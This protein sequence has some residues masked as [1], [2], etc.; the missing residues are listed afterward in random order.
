VSGMGIFERLRS[1]VAGPRLADELATLAGQSADLVNR[2][3]RHA[4]RLAYPKIAA[5]VRE[6]ADKE[7]EHQKIM[8]A[9]LAE[10]RMWPR[11]P[12]QPPHEG[13]SNWERLSIDLE[14]L[15]RFAR[16]LHQHAMR[17]EG[18]GADPALGEAL[19]KVANE[20]SEDEFEL[21]LLVSKLDPQ[22]LD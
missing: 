14:I 16:N 3:R 9:A 11:L 10:R 13:S 18:D 15:L 8:R 20:A 6:I 4:E 17:W 1:A 5:G 12:E 19:M 7:A 21:R 22:A 2:L